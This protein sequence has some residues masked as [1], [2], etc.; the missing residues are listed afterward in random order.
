[1][2]I[3]RSLRTVKAMFVR[4]CNFCHKFGHKWLECRSRL[5][6][7]QQQTSGTTTNVPQQTGDSNKQGSSSK[8]KSEQ[9]K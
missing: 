9:A 3:Q 5:R 1:M 2:V 4:N 8:G 7:I 6:Q